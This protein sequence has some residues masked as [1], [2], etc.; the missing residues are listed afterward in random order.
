MDQLYAAG[1]RVFVLMNTA[2]LQLAPLYANDTVNGVGENH[3]WP[4]KPTNHTA[5]AE[6]MHEYTTSINN[7]FKYQT[8]YET[9]VGKRYPGAS[10]VL[11]DVWQLISDIYDNPTAYLNGTQPANVEGFDQHC[12][13][14]QTDC[15]LQYEGDSKDSF[16]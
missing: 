9:L 13:I 16:L 3:Y 4:M 1:A 15:V 6:A 8:P 5:I 11:F 7:I 10:F 2:P 14:D 12:T